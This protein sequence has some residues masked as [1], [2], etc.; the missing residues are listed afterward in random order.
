[1]FTKNVLI[2]NSVSNLTIYVIQI[3]VTSGVPIHFLWKSPANTQACAEVE[4]N[5][6]TKQ[7]T[8]SCCSG[9]LKLVNPLHSEFKIHV[10]NVLAF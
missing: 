10:L 9:N 2:H 6:A 7:V 4:C 8:P 1:M 3:P 5:S